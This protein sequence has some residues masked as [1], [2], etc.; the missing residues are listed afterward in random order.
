MESNELT[1]DEQV[2]LDETLKF[3]QTHFYCVSCMEYCPKTAD[4]EGINTPDGILCEY[5]EEDR[6][7]YFAGGRW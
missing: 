3:F 4:C 2:K 6:A 1:H 7:K 5:C